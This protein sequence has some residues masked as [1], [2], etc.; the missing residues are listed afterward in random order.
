MLFAAVFISGAA[1]SFSSPAVF[2]LI[3]QIVPRKLLA[4]AAAWSSST[5]QTA[6][7]VG[8]ALGGLIYAACGPLAA[9][10]LPF[11]FQ[12]IAIICAS[13]LTRVTKQ[14]KSQGQREPFFKKR[15]LRASFYAHA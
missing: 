5:Y 7:I 2:S 6:S 1:R 8:P 15:S 10:A 3:P 11:L 14:L 9:F 12:F 4:P 13:S